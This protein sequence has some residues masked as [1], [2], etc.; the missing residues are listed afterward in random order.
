MN[1]LVMI[2]A[3]GCDARLYAPQVAALSDRVQPHVVTTADQRFAGMV[4]QVLEAAPDSFVILG[5][6]MGG[7]VAL[8]T[9]LA[10]PERVKGLVVIGSGA[11]PT[12]D[13]AGGMRRANRIAGGEQ[14]QVVE[15]LSTMVAHPAGPR[16]E[17]TRQAF[18]A[19]GA[20]FGTRAFEHQAIALASRT[21]LWNRVSEIACPVLCLWGANDQLSPPGD[22]RRLAESV[23][24]GRYVEMPA[25]GHFPSLEYPDE[26][27]AALGAWLAETGLT[28]A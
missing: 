28:R 5:T 23:K 13:A 15:E 26:T 19:M 25:C 16:G 22:G 6:S 12:A 3:F 10:A 11:G 14:R 8:E 20:A 4:D 18:L 1:T 7:R 9:A 17:V 2:P 21:D 27:T 24:H